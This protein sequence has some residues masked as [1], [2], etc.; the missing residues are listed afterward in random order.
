MGCANASLIA[1]MP[2]SRCLA[3]DMSYEIPFDFSERVPLIHGIV[4][5]RDFS[6]FLL[7]TGAPS[8][9]L[10]EDVVAALG[11]C[12]DDKNVV[13]VDTLQ[14]GTLDIGP[15][16]LQVSSFGQNRIDGVL[17]TQEVAGYSVTI[18]LDRSVCLLGESTHGDAA[19]SPLELLHGRPIVRIQHADAE[20]TFVLDTGS[21][22]NWLFLSGQDKLRRVGMGSDHSVNAK[23]ARQSFRTQQRKIVQK[24]RIGGRELAEVTFLL[25][26][27]FAGPN[28]PEDG[29]LG[30]GALVASGMAVVDIPGR[31][32]VLTNGSR[33]KQ[34]NQPD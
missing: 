29:I 16:D 15:V 26:D 5:G 18:D 30:L 13:H 2:M 25:S 32:F 28:A 20:L 22:G 31:R 4:N 34:T 9:Y 10:H 33:G 17:G 12:V 7:D 8:S 23:G 1:R 6:R 19:F 27:Q 3:D 11:R 14:F 24:M 21:S